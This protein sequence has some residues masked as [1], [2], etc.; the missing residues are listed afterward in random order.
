M[1]N[2]RKE[3]K[4]FKRDFY[5]VIKCKTELF[6][7]Y[8]LSVSVLV[9][10]W[11]IPMDCGEEEGSTGFLKSPKALAQDSVPPPTPKP[12]PKIGRAHV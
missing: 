11:T 4:I 6:Q 2:G 7:C 10:K 8:R 5:K 3:Q 12:F 1:S 9:H